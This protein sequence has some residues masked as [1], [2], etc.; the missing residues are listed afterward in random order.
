M[1]ADAYVQNAFAYE[2]ALDALLDTVG[3]TKSGPLQARRTLA[4]Q[5]PQL[6]KR[7]RR[8]LTHRPRNRKR[9]RCRLARRPRNRKRARHRLT[10]RP[11]NR[12]RARRRLTHRPRNRK[13]T[14]CVL[15]ASLVSVSV[16][17]T[18]AHTRS[19]F[20]KRTSTLRLGLSRRARR[21]S[22]PS[23]AVGA[24]HVRPTRTDE[25]LVGLRGRMSFSSTIQPEY[26]KAAA[27]R[28]SDARPSYM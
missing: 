9:A 13:R 7:A 19:P 24:A 18:R 14:A 21:T 26:A 10:R 17:R 28:V 12:K 8:R 20:R 6:L 11:R 27:G 16:P 22:R 1:P 4:V 3:L 23:R 15:D 2:T 5:R 25:T